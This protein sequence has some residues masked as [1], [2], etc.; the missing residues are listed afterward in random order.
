MKRTNIF[1]EKLF[2][3]GYIAGLEI[4]NA[5]CASPWAPSCRQPRRFSQLGT[6]RGLCRG[7]DGGAGIVYMVLTP[8]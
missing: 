6:V 2:E 8:V 7:A 4:K 5:S 1:R 3:R